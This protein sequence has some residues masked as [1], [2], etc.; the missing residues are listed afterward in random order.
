MAGRISWQVSVPGVLVAHCGYPL[1][2]GVLQH[3]RL[4][5]RDLCVTCLSVYLL[6]EPV[7]S[8]TPISRWLSA[9]NSVPDG[10][11]APVPAPPE[12]HG[13]GKVLF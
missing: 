5:S 9:P 11:S 7:F 12:T 10:R 8:R 4:P 1:F 3:D 2:R 13:P 6:P